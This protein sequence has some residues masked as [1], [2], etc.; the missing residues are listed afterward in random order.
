MTDRSLSTPTSHSSLGKNRDT[1]YITI[2]LVLFFLEFLDLSDNSLRRSSSTEKKIPDIQTNGS[3]SKNGDD[4]HKTVIPI[5]DTSPT[6]DNG[7]SVIPFQRTRHLIRRTP[8]I[9]L[10][11][12]TLI[13][14]SDLSPNK[15]SND[16]PAIT[17][18]NRSRRALT[19]P[20]VDNSE[21]NLNAQNDISPNFKK[22]LGSVGVL[23]GISN[24]DDLA[25]V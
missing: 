20:D 17:A 2:S 22:A 7:G 23:F 5:F 13:V 21:Q 8:S 24:H 12:N 16:S 15:D 11:K 9:P 4:A 25:F 19:D 3:S 1:F 14:N 10:K 6:S 18:A